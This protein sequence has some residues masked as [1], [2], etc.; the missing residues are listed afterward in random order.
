MNRTD[1][2]LA[3]ML[4]LQAR[5]Y[6]RAEDLAVQFE[7]SVRT[8]YRDVLALCEAGVPVVSTPGYG[9][10]L[11]PGYFLPPIMFT[12]EE[13][14]MLLLGS[15]FVAEQV[16]APYKQAVTRAS[17]KIEKLLPDAT[18]QEVEFLLDSFRFV[19]RPVP[20]PPESRAHLAL[21]QR[22]ILEREVLHLHYHARHGE[23]GARDVEPHGL[24]HME[25]TW[26]LGA[27]C[28]VRQDMRNFRLDRMDAV[29]PTGEHFERR[30]TFTLRRIPPMTHGPE[31]VLVR[32]AADALRW[33]REDG[34]YSYVRAETHPD[35][36]VLV[37]R[38]RDTRDLIP[39]LLS[40]GNAV[41][42]L[43]PPAVRDDLRAAA[44]AIAALYAAD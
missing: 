18:R 26:I 1:R 3:I 12:P 25:G 43:A 21:L 32:V 19:S 41:E 38:P 14:G 10:T 4:E 35:G 8:V 7:I 9:Y 17:K 44:A 16:D 30:Q 22:A 15:A 36:V 42:V 29:I 20:I 24:I 39:W 27:Y 11:T 13:A 40:W 34:H 28:R 23:P 2:L 33:V 31:D 37:F 5:R 6:T